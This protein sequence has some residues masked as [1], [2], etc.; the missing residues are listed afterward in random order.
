[1][2]LTYKNL[3]KLIKQLGHQVF[4]QKETD[5]LVLTFKKDLI[6]Y[7]VFIRIIQQQ[8]ILQIVLFLPCRAEEG[9]LADTLRLL[10]FFNKELD[11]PGFCYDELSKLLF[12][13]VVIPAFDK[14]VVSVM[15]LERILGSLPEI[16]HTFGPLT[17]L[18]ASGTKTF[19][20]ILEEFVKTGRK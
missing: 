19:Q 12:Y 16:A 9:T 5:Q 11:L 1:M 6:E 7:P 2:E 20:Q 8:T 17:Q 14:M 15:T 10:N 4:Y 3:E 13:R 18:V